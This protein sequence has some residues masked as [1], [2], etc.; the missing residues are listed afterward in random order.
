MAI[1]VSAETLDNFQLSKTLIHQKPKF[2]VS[3]IKPLQNREDNLDGTLDELDSR[4]A[5]PNRG[6]K[7]SSLPNHLR[8]LS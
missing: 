6:K 1:E 3:N 7:K 2:Y 4:D 5:N 8:G